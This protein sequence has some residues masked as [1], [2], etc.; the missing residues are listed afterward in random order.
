MNN[1][2]KDTIGNIIDNKMASILV[3]IARPQAGHRES[4]FGPLINK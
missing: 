4:L 2:V 1:V 3:E